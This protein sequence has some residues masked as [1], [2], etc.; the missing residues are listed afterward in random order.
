MQLHQL[1]LNSAKKAKKRIGRGGKKGTYSGRGIKGQKSRSGR[2]PRIGFVG[3]DRPLHKMVPKPRGER[4][5]LDIKEGQ[6]L[7]RL[8]LIKKPV[9]INLDKIEEKFSEGEIVSPINLLKKGLIAKIKGRIPQVKILGRGELKK[10]L[11]FEN[12]ILSKKV[13]KKK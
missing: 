12:V 1:K 5:S 6:K 3:G 10:K 7:S 8:R 13:Q 11:K 4:G 2:H 9:I